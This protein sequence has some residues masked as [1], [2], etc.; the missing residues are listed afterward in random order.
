MLFFPLYFFS[1]LG[2]RRCESPF[3]I[4]SESI[5]DFRDKGFT[6]GACIILK[7]SGQYKGSQRKHWESI[8][9]RIWFG[10]Q[11]ELNCM[12]L[13]IIYETIHKSLTEI[14]ISFLIKGYKRFVCYD[15]NLIIF[16]LPQLKR[17]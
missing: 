14:S 7:P 17:L 13:I 2:S 8:S 16:V 10:K 5:R 4:L 11:L 15:W 1:R 6:A 9:V 12:V 3:D